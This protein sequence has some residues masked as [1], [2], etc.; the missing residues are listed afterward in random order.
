M[1]ERFE[2][3]SF[4]IAEIQRYITKISSDEMKKHGLS[5]THARY[6]IIMN[7]Q[8]SG[9]TASRLGVLCNRNKAEVSRVIAD[10]QS[11]GLI[12]RE[13]QS[14]NYRVKLC[15]T[16]KGTE[17]AK[18]IQ[19]RVNLAVAQAGTGLSEKHRRI[20]YDA[21][22]LIAE[23]LEAISKNGLS[24]NLTHNEKTPLGE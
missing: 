9:I 23:N 12:E 15:L 14:A 3:F 19:E 13:S 16:H 18:S 24:E 6:L 4:V 11:K 1:L 22:Y 5:G 17:T 10:L 7:K 21:L 8:S 20:L 2:K